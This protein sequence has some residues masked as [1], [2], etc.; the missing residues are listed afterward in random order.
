MRQR[1]RTAHDR[2]PRLAR[3]A[4]FT[5][6][7][8]VA[9]AGCGGEEASIST[10]STTVARA[11]SATTSAT[12]TPPPITSTDPA[13]PIAAQ[14]TVDPYEGIPLVDHVEWTENVDGPRLL[15]FPSEAGRRTTYPG[16]DERAWQEVLTQSPAADAPGMRD[17]FVCHWDWARLVQP[18]KPSWNLEPWRPA[19]GYPATVQASCNPGGPER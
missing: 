9:V 18:N 19:V 14:P 4:G 16:S 10:P 15:V 3:G 5:L 8:S 12:P 1:T 6:L 13:T 7:V 2:R 11:L 17:Q